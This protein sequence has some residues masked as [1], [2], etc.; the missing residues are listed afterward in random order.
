MLIKL[1]H[2]NLNPANI[3]EFEKLSQDIDL[4]IE[5][6]MSK[7]AQELKVIA[8]QAKDFLYFTCV[9]MHAAE[10]A[11]LDDNGEFK[12]LADGSPVSATWEPIGESVKWV[13]NDPKVMP[14]KNN[15]C[16]VP[17]TDILMA[18]GSRKAV[19]DIV[20]GDEVITHKGRV[21]KVI[22]V[23]KHENNSEIY[24]L[25]VKHHPKLQITSEHPL[26]ALS[27][28]EVRKR[29]IKDLRNLQTSPAW[30]KAGDVEAGDVLLSL[31]SVEGTPCEDLTPGQARLLG[32]FAAEGF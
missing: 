31:R 12:K 9:M 24:N 8:P 2:S 32:Y 22:E 16:L 15:N 5:Q 27:G 28:S 13:C 23:F 26:Y 30:I 17:G 14:Y 11:L 20:V 29:S 21:K 6:K 25:K 19:E 4:D 18:D 3:Q 7:F 10:A 1:G